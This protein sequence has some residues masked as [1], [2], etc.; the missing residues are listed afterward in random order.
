MSSIPW[1]NVI[2]VDCCES[3]EQGGSPSPVSVP[4]PTFLLA[5][6]Q[7][8]PLAFTYFHA[9]D[10]LDRKVI[11]G[12]GEC[13]LLHVQCRLLRDAEFEVGAQR[14]VEGLEGGHCG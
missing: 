3:V 12:Q 6:R 8:F 7:N 10:G 13:F 14:R 11:A 1:H 5:D 9:R 2:S 4:A